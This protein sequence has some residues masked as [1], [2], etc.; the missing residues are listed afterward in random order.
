MNKKINA[1]FEGGG[2][3]GIGHVGAAC[4]F[5][6]K[7]YEFI[8]LAG[9]SAGAIVASL[10]AAGYQ[11]EEIK[12][13]MS[14]LNYLKFKQ[15]SFLTRFGTVGKVISV[16]QNYGM[17]SS[18]YFEKWLNDLLRKKNKVFFGDIKN[19]R[20]PCGNVPYTL[21]ITASDLT[22]KRLL[23]L[24]NDLP[25]FCIDPD[26][27]SIAKAVRMSMNIPIFYKPYKLRDCNGKEHY[28]V[29][30]GLL[31]NYPIWLFDHVQSNCQC[32]TVGFKFVNQNKNVEE[33]KM[34]Q[35]NMNIVD[36]V[37]SLVATALNAKDKQ[38]ISSSKGDF[39]RTVTIP[40]DITINRKTKN[41]S[42]T[43]F[44]ISKEESEAL[45]YNGVKAANQFLN[46]WNYDQWKRSYQ[47]PIQQGNLIYMKK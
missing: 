46:I 44:G 1:V 19:Y 39:Q 31:S 42:A 37:M 30:G 23:I 47:K 17:Y 35:T 10:L 3:R 38:Y 27:F 15:E 13:E 2:I 33:R 7:G 6:Q 24:P 21:Q 20:Y 5:E 34:N 32:S 9:S 8:N 4:V 41:I 16:L 18:D 29:D 26:T 25:D 14:T 28:I 12:K 11:C 22:D 43:D 45:F 40:T 36:Y